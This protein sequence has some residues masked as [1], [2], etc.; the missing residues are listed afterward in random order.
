MLGQGRTYVV[1]GQRGAGRTY[2]VAAVVVL[3]RV[4]AR[5]AEQR[6]PAMEKGSPQLMLPPPQTRY[7]S[8]LPM[9]PLWKNIL[10]DKYF[11]SKQY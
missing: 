11:Y 9:S 7:S 1:A 4:R 5:G 3:V 6:T 10:Q 2:I 8:D